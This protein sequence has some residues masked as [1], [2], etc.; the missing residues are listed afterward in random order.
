[1]SAVRQTAASHRQ[2][3]WYESGSQSGE[4]S[5]TLLEDDLFALNQAADSR[6]VP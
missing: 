5:N 3:Q 2:S 6:V 1:M 4:R